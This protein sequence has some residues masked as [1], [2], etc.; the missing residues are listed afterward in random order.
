M[1]IRFLRHLDSHHTA[2]LDWILILIG[3]L[4]AML[5]WPVTQP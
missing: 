4:L 3:S 5:F 2:W 1:A